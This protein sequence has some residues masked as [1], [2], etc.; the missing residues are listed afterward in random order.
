MSKKVRVAT[1][2]QLGQGHA[3]LA[4]NRRAAEQL[5]EVA[6]T[7]KPD[8]VCLPETFLETGVSLQ[9]LG[10]AA[11]T[12]PGPTTDRMAALARQYGCYIICPLTVRRGDLYTND[13]VLIDRQG[14]IAG[15]YSKI[16]PVVEGS[17]FVSLEKG[18]TPGSE[19]KV[20]DTDFGRIGMQICFDINWAETWAELKAKGAEIVF[21]S[22]AYGGGKHLSIHAWNNRYYVVSSVKTEHARIID[23]MGEVVGMTDRQ[24]PVITRTLDLDVG[25]F[26]TDFNGSQLAALQAEYGPDI[27][28]KLWREEGLF[29][30]ESNRE[31][32]SVADIT[33]RFALD[34]LDEYLG[35]NDVLQDAW[36]R[37]V[38]PPDLTPRYLGR[39]QWV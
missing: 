5:V 4:Q 28:I 23:I 35:R 17:E 24:R 14:R 12:V 19:A 3:M 25:L 11:E 15:A 1:V 31:N 18:M 2:A 16:H 27:T 21:W 30:L 6:A 34:P 37:G 39:E 13:A 9:N 10:Q 33:D 26:H 32:L 20:F 8:I 36:R 22:S 7:E 29:T 38:P